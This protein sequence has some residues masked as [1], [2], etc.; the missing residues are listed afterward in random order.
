MLHSHQRTLDPAQTHVWY[1]KLGHAQSETEW[2]YDLLSL[3]ER[4]RAQRFRFRIHRARFVVA[5]ALLRILLGGY[6]R[7]PPEMIEFVYDAHGKP[8]LRD[9]SLQFNV[10]HCEDRGL[11][12]FNARHRLGVDIERVRPMMDM[13]QIAERFFSSSEAQ[14]L[15]SLPLNSRDDAF[16]RCWTRKEAFIKATGEGLSFPLERFVVSCDEPACLLHLDA[17]KD[18]ASNWALHHLAPEA[19]YVGALAVRDRESLLLNFSFPFD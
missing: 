14:T 9:Q 19:G 1:S 11:F 16:F 3:H 7:R 10:S 2:A 15:S 8:A 13:I 12:A 6:L 4:E 5:R 17:D 18:E